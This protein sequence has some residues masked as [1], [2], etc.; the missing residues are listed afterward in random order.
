VKL[1]IGCGTNIIAGYINVDHAACYKP[2]VVADLEQGWPWPDN[3]VDE[4]LA[5]H[6]LEHIANFKHITQSI[7]R[8]LK[9]G[10]FVDIRVPH[11][12]H[13]HFLGD[14]THVRPI[15]PAVLDLCSRKN[16]KKWRETGAANS[17]L[18][19]QWEVDMELKHVSF[20]LASPWEERFHAHEISEAELNVAMDQLNNV[21]QQINMIWQ[22]AS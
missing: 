11:P 18:A 13:D 7:Y 4:I 15:V 19:D 5:S 20:V 9:I 8:V 14:P 22:K 16:C 10:G 3:S 17:Q 6:I 2:D 21:C 1:N 12:R